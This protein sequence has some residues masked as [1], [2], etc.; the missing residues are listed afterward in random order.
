[1]KLDFDE[2]IFSGKKSEILTFYKYIY[3]MILIILNRKFLYSPN[4]T[5][6]LNAKIREAYRNEVLTTDI[7]N[8]VKG[9]TEVGII[10]LFQRIKDDIQTEKEDVEIRKC[11]GQF[12][13]QLLNLVP[14]QL[15][16]PLARSAKD[17]LDTVMNEETPK[18]V[19]QAFGNP[20]TK[21]VDD[22]N[23]DPSILEV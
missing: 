6:W 10:D 5:P 9:A 7:K 18:Q 15:K 17:I 2:G 14:V 16:D 4:F 22:D 12:L 19:E 13:I 21:Y 8:L 1:M 11:L 23:E 3:L 20:E